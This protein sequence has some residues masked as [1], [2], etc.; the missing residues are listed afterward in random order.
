MQQLLPQFYNTNRRTDKLTR[1]NKK[2]ESAE[3]NSSR[4]QNEIDSCTKASP[5]DITE[6]DEFSTQYTPGW[7]RELSTLLQGRR[8]IQTSLLVFLDEGCPRQLAGTRKKRFVYSTRDQ[9][10]KALSQGFLRF[11]FSKII[12]LGTDNAHGIH[13][14]LT[15]SWPPFPLFLPPFGRGSRWTF[16]NLGFWDEG[17]FLVS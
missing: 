6:E 3:N 16:F 1:N 11:S 9:I 10:R 7:G 2:S 8:R 4:K 5:Q 12:M 13:R 14:Q 15:S 17:M